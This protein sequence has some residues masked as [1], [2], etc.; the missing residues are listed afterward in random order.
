MVGPQAFQY[1]TCLGNCKRSIL[2]VGFPKNI[3]CLSTSEYAAEG[4][5]VLCSFLVTLWRHN[6]WQSRACVSGSSR[7]FFWG[8][9]TQLT[10]ANHRI[11]IIRAAWS[12]LQSWIQLFNQSLEHCRLTAFVRCTTRKLR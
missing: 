3:P 12:D 5:Q 7:F 9:G 11:K 1:G 10:Y 6:D 4:L 8:G 2:G